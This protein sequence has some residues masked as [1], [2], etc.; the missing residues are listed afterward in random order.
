LDGYLPLDFDERLAEAFSRHMWPLLNGR[1]GRFAFR[2]REP[3]RV[4]SHHLDFWLPYID[5]VAQRRMRL[6]GLASRRRTTRTS[7]EIK[8]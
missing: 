7:N 2:D 4:L 1:S 6:N 8:R 3:I 5:V